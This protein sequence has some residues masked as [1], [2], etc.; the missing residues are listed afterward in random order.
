MP[1]IRRLDTILALAGAIGA[2]GL[3][4]WFLS[5]TSDYLYPIVGGL[6]MLACLVYLAIRN[7][8]ELSELLEEYGGHNS[9]YFIL[10][11]LFF[12]L[13]AGAL[14]LVAARPEIYSTPLGYYI[15][16]TLAA[17][18]LALEIM[19]LPHHRGYPY[20]VLG[21]IILLGLAL[22]WIPQTIFPGLLGIDPYFHEQFTLS[23]LDSGHVP[24]DNLYSSFPAMHIA[25]GST[26]LIADLS[27]KTATMLFTGTAY[28]VVSLSFVFLL[29]RAVFGSKLGLLA[30]L[31]LAGAAFFIHFGWWTVPNTYAAIFLPVLAYLLFKLRAQFPIRATLI[32]M[33]LM[34]A[35]IVTHTIGALGV[36][37]LLIVFW[38]GNHFY[39][40][41]RNSDYRT[42]AADWWQE[43]GNQPVS[44]TLAVFFG[45]AM[46][47]WW[48]LT[49]TEAIDTLTELVRYGFSL[50]L[51]DPPLDESTVY[52]STI[53]LWEKLLGLLA[54][55]AFWA[56]SFIGVLAAFSLKA[57]NRHIVLLAIGG[58]L[59]VALGFFSL[60]LNLGTLPG[61]W[62]FLSL[63]MLAIPAAL[64]LMLLAGGLKRN[65]RGIVLMPVFVAIL[66]F[67]SITSPTAS[68]DNYV[69]SE[70]TTVRYAFKASEMAAYNTLPE[71]WVGSLGADYYATTYFRFTQMYD[72]TESIL[73][74]DFSGSEGLIIFRNGLLNEP[75]NLPGVYQ[76]GYD[77]HPTLE[78]QGYILIYTTGT[79]E[80]YR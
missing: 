43:T 76:L 14:V 52:A 67:L 25:S 4:A 66:V 47:S 3:T 54:Y 77:P 36:A 71:L 48:L 65:G 28:V 60:P 61:R 5:S 19:V 59:L 79:T 46:F 11:I 10:N 72:I 34:A 78:E 73:G 35:L 70:K 40:W 38:L 17:A 2:G 69:W 41:V 44:L 33:G 75:T 24:T 27:Y 32:V 62:Q 26:M 30:A 68:I 74:K 64:G 1:F 56:V 39:G 13:L 50:E 42:A 23:I 63:F 57:G 49:S 12:L 53:P 45:V 18:V 51:S 16:L 58:L 21:K 8:V 6:S 80:A 15:C 29:G 22:I 37:L 9:T 7:R 20:L 55:A 31:L